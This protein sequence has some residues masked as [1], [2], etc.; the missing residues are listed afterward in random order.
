MRLR[1]QLSLSVFV[2]LVFLAGLSR[3]A[4]THRRG[5]PYEQAF[6]E[7]KPVLSKADLAL[8]WSNAGMTLVWKGYEYIY[9]N[10]TVINDGETQRER[11]TKKRRRL[12]MKNLAK[13][14]SGVDYQADPSEFYVWQQLIAPDQDGRVNIEICYETEEAISELHCTLVEVSASGFAF[15]ISSA[16]DNTPRLSRNGTAGS[17][18]FQAPTS[19][20]TIE[21][22]R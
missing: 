1:T 12:P 15:L 14:G 19:S 20:C 5:L 11:W 16:A 7:T 17:M 2:N 22:A 4:V 13:R 6:P 8:P 9:D 10:Y 18:G 3:C 21:D